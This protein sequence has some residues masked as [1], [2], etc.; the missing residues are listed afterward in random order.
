MNVAAEEREM[1][2]EYRNDMITRLGYAELQRSVAPV[3]LCLAM[4]KSCLFLVM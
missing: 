4:V 3:F 1:K 2:T